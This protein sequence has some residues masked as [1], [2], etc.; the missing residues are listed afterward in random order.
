M[1]IEDIQRM[2]HD[3]LEKGSIENDYIEY[4]KSATFKDK[5][6]K[7]I[8]AFANNYMN[9]AILAAVGFGEYKDVDEAADKIVKTKDVYTPSVDIAAK[10]EEK[11]RK[12]VE[13]IIGEYLS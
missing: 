2:A 10:Y 12:F 1:R 7:T 6:L 5:I 4:K 11:Y 3:I 13:T 9:A 8:C